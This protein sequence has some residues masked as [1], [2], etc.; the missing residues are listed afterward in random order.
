[1]FLF[2][3]VGVVSLVFLGGASGGLDLSTASGDLPGLSATCILL[4]LAFVLTVVNLLVFPRLKFE[5]YAML[6]FL[7]DLVLSAAVAVQACRF[8][9]F[10]G[11]WG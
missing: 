10:L 11:G 1:M 3:L 8:W 6:L 7:L 9:G 5:E 4:P 2:Q